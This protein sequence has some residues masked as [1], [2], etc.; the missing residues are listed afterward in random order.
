MARKF[1]R[2]LF[3]RVREI[4]K[5]LT[6][7]KKL[8]FIPL[9]QFDEEKTAYDSFSEDKNPPVEN[10]KE[11]DIIHEY[12]VISDY[13]IDMISFEKV[14]EVCEDP[15]CG[16]V[17]DEKSEL[18]PEYSFGEDD[19]DG[20]L[21]EKTIC[22]IQNDYQKVADL[23][24][25]SLREYLLCK[26][27]QEAFACTYVEGQL[28]HETR[29]DISFESLQYFLS[30]KF[31]FGTLLSDSEPQ[32]VTNKSLLF[33]TVETCRWC[34]KELST[35]PEVQLDLILYVQID[36]PIMN[37][38]LIVISN[39]DHLFVVVASPEKLGSHLKQLLGEA[40]LRLQELGGLLDEPCS[41]LNTRA[42]FSS[43]IGS[44][45]QTSAMSGEKNV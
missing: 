44:A 28:L 31:D 4:K 41:Q 13:D 6:E 29:Q 7:T 26:V 19:K 27:L 33:K 25:E 37:L 24:C 22:K 36:K 21:E 18:V 39:H 20:V 15:D 3:R 2:W 40:E 14:E 1:L 9:I 8:E 35:F 12:P 5:K 17:E 11:N 43:I 34:K 23:M 45:Y 30:S 32:Q 16:R 38:S 42:S 10:P